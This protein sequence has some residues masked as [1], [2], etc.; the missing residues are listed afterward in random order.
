M[1]KNLK[2]S[3]IVDRSLTDNEMNILSGGGV[4]NCTSGLCKLQEWD[5]HYDWHE[6][7]LYENLQQVARYI[8]L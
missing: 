1:K 3:K 4:E 5:D 2:I 7:W 6:D 8:N